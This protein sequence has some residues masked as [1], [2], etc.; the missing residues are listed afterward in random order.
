[1]R[2]RL[3]LFEQDKINAADEV[4]SSALTPCEKKKACQTNPC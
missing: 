1:M 3:S 4:L 2:N